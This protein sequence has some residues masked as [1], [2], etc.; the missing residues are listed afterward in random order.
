MKTH[1][2]RF[3]RTYVA[4]L[5][6]ATLVA[7]LAVAGTALLVE[8]SSAAP[9]APPTNSVEPRISGTTR[10]GE[11]LRT[12][13]GTWA[14]SLGPISY[15]FRWYRCDG[16]GQ[17]DASDCGR[18]S[19][20][21][22]TT[23]QL[24]AADAGF[25]IRSQVV[26]TNRDGSRTA[27][28]N[29]TA[30]ITAAAPVN[31]EEPSISGSTQLGNRLTASPGEWSG[32]RPI[33]YAFQWLR[34]TAQGEGCSQ[35]AGGTDSTY[36][37]VE[38]DV[39]RTLRVT[40]TAENARGRTSK[41][42]NPTAVVTRATPPPPP[43]GSSIPV[44]DLRPAGDRLSV[45]QVRFSPN[46]VTSPTAPITVRVR[47]TARQANP[48]RGALVFMR[49]TPRVVQGQTQTTQAD[50]WVT[51]TL[52]P[53]SQFPQPRSGFNVQFFIKAYRQGDRANALTDYRLVQVRLAG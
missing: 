52:V 1:A 13:R 4:I 10:V 40:V 11:V 22:N 46:P 3:Q 38:Q 2:S 23:Y 43:P 5:G 7:G 32:V 33:T 47:V 36:T 29:P 49:A 44:D 9:A 24:R 12:T 39:G 25:R 42:S 21:Q 53:N 15:Q 34:C 37:T 31:T 18:I 28:S 51:L 14:S 20:A 27:T 26:A 50:G 41:R 30:V 45:S 17:P 35:I 6:L 16:R 8:S 48:V 19:N